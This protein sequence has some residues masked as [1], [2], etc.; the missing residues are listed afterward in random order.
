[1]RMGATKKDF[2]NVVAIHP[3]SSEEL[4]TMRWTQFSLYPSWI[5][6]TTVNSNR[7]LGV[8]LMHTAQ[9]LSKLV[10]KSPHVS[11]FMARFTFIHCEKFSNLKINTF[12]F[13]NRIWSCL[14]YI[15]IRKCVPHLYRQCTLYV[16]ALDS[17]A[18]LFW[19]KSPPRTLAVKT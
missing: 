9:C 18:I 19:V 5:L 17:G 11:T 4:V 12:P 3:T 1:M 6:I 7:S 15:K 8:A 14:I 13:S 2:D 10:K 16:R